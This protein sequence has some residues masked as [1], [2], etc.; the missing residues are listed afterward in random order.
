MS[1]RGLRIKVTVTMVVSIAVLGIIASFLLPA[2]DG[3]R[4]Y[5]AFEERLRFNAATLASMLQLAPQNEWERVLK[6]Q[7]DTDGHA[8]WAVV[9][10]A[11]GEKL[12]RVEAKGLPEDLIL[13]ERSRAAKA[14]HVQNYVRVVVPVRTG[15]DGIMLT[16]GF[17]DESFTTV[18]EARV[19]TR[20]IFAACA[21]FAFGLLGFFLGSRFTAPLKKTSDRLTKVSQDLLS[22][23]RAREASAAEEAAAV[24]ETRRTMDMLLSSAQKIADSASAVLGNAERTLDGNREIAER[25]EL[26]NRH[27]EK[28]A[29]I[30]ASIMQVADRT[31]LLALNAALEGT[32]AGEAG[33]GFTLVAK[34]MR[35]LAE[36]VMDSVEGIR[37]LM[38]DV[39]TAGQGAV[40][41]SHDGT[42]FSEETT[43][44]VREIALVTQ[45]QRKA[46]EQVSRS[47]DEMTEL[48][49]H[50]MADIKQT[51]RSAAE[52][53]Q[54]SRLL[55]ELVATSDE[56]AQGKA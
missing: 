43:R 32:K 16:V 51:T 17:S 42:G 1:M 19:R 23:A 18:K 22:A 53:S 4:H 27:A 13:F 8:R 20:L 52:L 15:T 41:A 30:L 29:E 56:A 44:S 9:L 7:L 40:E 6:L 21:I 49:N 50:A 55:A 28:V 48:L 35:R 39:R 26:L 33:K 24:E 38:R 10:G 36:N 2:M 3:D 45:Q 37:R 12:A 34:E 31:D 5:D 54:V 25:I 14:T 11:Q 47:M 46:T